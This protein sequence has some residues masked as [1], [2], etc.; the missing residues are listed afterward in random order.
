LR[1]SPG[2]GGV[3]R[4]KLFI[5]AQASIDPGGPAQSKVLLRAF[6]QKLL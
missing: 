3:R 6:H 2:S 1:P 5:E 4:P